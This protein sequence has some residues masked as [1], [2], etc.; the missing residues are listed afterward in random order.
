ME[1][2]DLSKGTLHYDQLNNEL[3][4]LVNGKSAIGDNIGS[5]YGVYKIMYFTSAQSGR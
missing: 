4:A 3:S 2:F 1:T 5:N